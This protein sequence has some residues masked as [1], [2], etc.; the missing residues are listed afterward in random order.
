[1]ELSKLHQTDKVVSA[2]PFF[3][4]EEGIATSI[5]ILKGELLKEHVTKIPA[6]LLCVSGKVIFEN[7]QSHKET[8]LSGD[9][10]LITPMVKHWVQAEEDSQLA[11]LK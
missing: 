3:K 10:I 8:L 7:E 1:M 2:K 5:Q 9:Y 6:L 11:L 4:M